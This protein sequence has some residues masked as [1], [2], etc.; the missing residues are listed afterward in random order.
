[1]KEENIKKL[2]PYLFWL[3]FRDYSIDLS[4]VKDKFAEL[5]ISACNEYRNCKERGLPKFEGWGMP[6]HM[7]KCGR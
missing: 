1:M 7:C 4:D 3:G 2:E 6:L 5:L